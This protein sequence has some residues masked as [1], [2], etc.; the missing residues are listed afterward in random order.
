MQDIEN[1]PKFENKRRIREIGKCWEN[2]ENILGTFYDLR[3]NPRYRGNCKISEDIINLVRIPKRLATL[4]T[5]VTTQ[6][7]TSS[8][9]FSN[10][11]AYVTLLSK[12]QQFQ[13]YQPSLAADR[14]V[15]AWLKVTGC[16]HGRN[17]PGP[18]VQLAT[19]GFDSRR[20]PKRPNGR[21]WSWRRNW[22]FSAR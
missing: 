18:Y 6:S 7:G 3:N 16:K 10:F 4:K 9:D 13:A 14:Q 22:T 8:L 2:E 12:C 20:R 1:T 5:I 17:Y 19:P 11:V 21:L 15:D